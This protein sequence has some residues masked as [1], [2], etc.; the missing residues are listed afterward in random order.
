MLFFSCSILAYARRVNAYVYI[1]AA[2]IY[3]TTAMYVCMY[4]YVSI[5]KNLIFVFMYVC[6]FF[7]SFVFVC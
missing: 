7:C 5:L 6:D 4:V 1:D 3:V 2:K